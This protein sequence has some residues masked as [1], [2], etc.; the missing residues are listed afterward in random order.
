[1]ADTRRTLS[2]LQT[3]LADNTT[4]AISA[5][6]IRDVLF[7][8]SP[9]HA[10]M[11]I[12]SPAA[13][14]VSQTSTYVKVAGTTA[15]TYLKEFDM[16]AN[17]RL[18]YIGTPVIHVHCAITVDVTTA[19]NNQL[20]SFRIAKNG[21]ATGDDAVASTVDHKTGAS[22]DVISTALHY[23][24]MMSY[25]DYLELFCANE[26]TASNMTIPHMYFFVLG[27]LS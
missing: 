27:M 3:L 16:P 10:T 8:A 19:S 13:T 7:S 18:R 9:P 21:V 4:G 23:D 11:Y 24:T 20:A 25:G 5:Q 17:N 15:S 22:T 1:M 14:T 26:T 2:D 6:D 12:T